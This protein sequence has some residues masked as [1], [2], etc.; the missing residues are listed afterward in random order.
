MRP[1]LYIYTSGTTGLPKAA[2]V[3]HYRL[4]HWSHWFAGMMDTGPTDRMYNCLPMY[5]SVGGVVAT[6]AM[7]VGGGSVVIRERFSASRL[8]ARHRRRALHAVPIHRRA[9]PLSRER[10]PQPRAK[11]AHRLRLR[12]GNGLRPDVWE[13]FQERFRIPHILEFYA[14]TEGNF[15]LYNCEGKPGAIGR[16]PSFL[17]ASLAGRARE[18]RRRARSAVA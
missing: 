16:I 6:G 9:V 5:H 15:S 7:L 1:A 8:L 11:R 13:H 18:I 12:C 10:P 2:N 4:M 14:A 17:C 3:S